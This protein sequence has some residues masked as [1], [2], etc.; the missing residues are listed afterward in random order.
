[1]KPSLGQAGLTA[2]A[3]GTLSLVASVG[4]ITP[5]SNVEV[6]NELVT[7]S[8]STDSSPLVASTGRLPVVTSGTAAPPAMREVE[9]VVYP[10]HAEATVTLTDE[11]GAE[12]SGT[13][14]V[15]AAVTG[16]VTVE[17]S[18]EGMRP[19][20]HVIAGDSSD[21]VEIY[22]D[23]IDQ[24]VDRTMVMTTGSAPKQV[25]FTPDG[26][27]LWVT[28]LA[29]SG[30]EIYDP[31]TGALL[32]VIDLPEAGS[33]ELIFDRAGTTAW[34][35][36]MET[37]TVYEIDVDERRIIRELATGGSWTKVMALSPDGTRLWASN[38]ISNDV[39]EFDLS[40]GEV[41][42][43]IPTVTTPRGLAVDAG[44]TRLYVAGY[45]AGEL[46]VVDLA[47]GE[48]R[49]IH[50]SG[51]ALRHLVADP[52]SGLV[53]ASDMARDVILVIES[54][55]DRVTTLG[56][57]DR[58]PNTIDVTP[59][60]AILAVS[61]RGRNNPETYYLP[62]P[63]WGSVLLLDTA[64]GRVLDAIVGG[65]QPTGLDISADGKW[66]AFSDFLDNRVTIVALPGVEELRA[67]GGGRADTYGAD[68]DK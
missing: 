23:P 60:G 37:A 18:A 44:A 3:L 7:T 15:D 32:S 65:N 19:E 31:V 10:S 66:L 39:S 30:L 8:T 28:L 5:A 9:V 63:E 43:R 6:T 53:Y 13:G 51:G 61:N 1:M 56:T 59:D 25:A 46:E 52:S 42:R 50:H 41:I 17:A 58:L 27:E 67:A 68:L 22:L 14:T 20:S 24:V 11:T 49:I 26:D 16:A 57:T 62:G 35:S 40:T 38:W 33:V 29:G 47:T 12:I 48:G 2:V 34:V 64:D 55:T 21:L 54:A 45:D 4:A 36:Q